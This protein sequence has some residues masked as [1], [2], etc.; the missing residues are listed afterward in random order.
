MSGKDIQQEFEGVMDDVHKLHEGTLE[1]YPQT[2]RNGA[3]AIDIDII[4]RRHP[5]FGEFLG[6]GDDVLHLDE[7]GQCELARIEENM[8]DEDA[9]LEQRSELL[10]KFFEYYAVKNRIIPNEKEVQ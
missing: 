6:N 7:Y 9:T 10:R 8:L 3:H 5:L 4:T 1:G 2:V